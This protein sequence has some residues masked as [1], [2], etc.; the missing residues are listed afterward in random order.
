MAK[1][2]TCTCGRIVT[3]AR[4]KKCWRCGRD[5]ARIREVTR[6]RY[7]Y[8][9]DVMGEPGWKAQMAMHSVVAMQCMY[10]N[11]EFPPELV[12]RRRCGP[13]PRLTKV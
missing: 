5:Y 1:G 11:H 3:Q 6:A 8:V 12:A 13:K 2:D 7:R 9:K 4:A 10:P